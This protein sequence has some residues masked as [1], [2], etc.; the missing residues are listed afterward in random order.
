MFG[1]RRRIVVATGDTLE[2]AMA[3]PAIRAW[4]IATALSR[5]H[6]VELVTDNRCEGVEH[7]DFRV[8]RVTPRELRDSSTGA[9]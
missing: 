1:E 5:E 8:R 6:D 2:P 3:G 9:T 4:Q 7:P